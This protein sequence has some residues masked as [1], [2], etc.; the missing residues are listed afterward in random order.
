MSYF[1]IGVACVIC[2]NS[3]PLSKEEMSAMLSNVAT[4]VKVCEQCKAAILM[5]RESMEENK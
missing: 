5:V 4:P 1:E 2:G 3:V